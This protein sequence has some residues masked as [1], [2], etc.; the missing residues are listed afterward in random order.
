MQCSEQKACILYLKPESNNCHVNAGWARCVLKWQMHLTN[1]KLS[2][3]NTA[4]SSLQTRLQLFLCCC[5]VGK[6]CAYM[7][8]A[9]DGQQGAALWQPRQGHQH[10]RSAGVPTS[11]ALHRLQVC[12]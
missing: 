3:L 8:D 5:R 10:G 4:L 2:A 7:A 9:A 12:K 1:S 6:V 11:R